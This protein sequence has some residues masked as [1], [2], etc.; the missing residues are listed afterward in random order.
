MSFRDWDI[1]VLLSVTYKELVNIVRRMRVLL[2][3]FS[4]EASSIILEV[5]AR[6]TSSAIR[7]SRP[8]ASSA[9]VLSSSFDEALVTHF[10]LNV[11]KFASRT[12]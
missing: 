12:A 9:A 1:S 5:E 3:A 4:K 2:Y 8:I 11:R 10:G 6:I 7:G